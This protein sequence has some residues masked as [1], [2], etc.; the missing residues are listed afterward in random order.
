MPSLHHQLNQITELQTLYQSQLRAQSRQS[1]RALEL[2][3]QSYGQSS[4]ANTSFE[5]YRN[6][7]QR[8]SSMGLQH[9]SL[10]TSA[11]MPSYHSS[12]ESHSRMEPLRISET[13]SI[14]PLQILQSVFKSSRTEM[15]KSVL[16]VNTIAGGS[17]VGLPYFIQALVHAVQLGWSKIPKSFF[18]YALPVLFVAVIMFLGIRWVASLPDC[19]TVPENTSC[20]SSPK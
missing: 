12:L 20:T 1:Q 7:L 3:R 13:R 4:F 18:S 11:S 19:S 8:L 10:S 9:S 17:M 6:S 5:D 15:I 2:Q 16:S 14:T